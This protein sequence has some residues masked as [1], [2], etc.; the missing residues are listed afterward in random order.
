MAVYILRRN[1]DSPPARDTCAPGDTVIM[2][3]GDILVWTGAMWTLLPGRYLSVDELKE[4]V[5][6]VATG[7]PDTPATFVAD[8]AGAIGHED[9]VR[10]AAGVCERL[11]GG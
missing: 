6:Y 2:A 11:S 10:R 9:F 3:S 7:W 4:F 5:A 8:M 1:S